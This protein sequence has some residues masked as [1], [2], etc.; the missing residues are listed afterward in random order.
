MKAKSPHVK[1]HERLQKRIKAQANL[2]LTSLMDIFTILVFFLLVNS[3]NPSKLPDAKRLSLPHSIAETTPKDTLV[4]M[5]TRDDVLVQDM[6]VSTVN[7]I[8]ALKTDLIPSLASELKYRATK[9]VATLNE[10]GI[11]EREITILGDEKT[12]YAVVRK[13][14]ATCSENDYAKI[15]F[16]VVRGGKQ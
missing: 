8:K 9:T 14:M 2:S 15:S 5:V 6:K 3:T 13:I 16:A 1:R 11:P 10:R 12:P 7:E 4:I